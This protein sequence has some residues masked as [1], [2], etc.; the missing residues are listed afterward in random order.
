MK[1]PKQHCE[2]ESIPLRQTGAIDGP[3][4][5]NGIKQVFAFAEYWPLV[6]TGQFEFTPLYRPEI[7]PEIAGDDSE[8]DHRGK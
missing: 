2:F 4:Q 1:F 3:F 5:D 8:A 6:A 7:H